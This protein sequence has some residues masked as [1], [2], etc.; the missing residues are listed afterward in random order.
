MYMPGRLRTASSPSRTVMFWASYEPLPFEPFFFAG[1]SAKSFL[2]PRKAPTPEPLS[3][4]SGRYIR[5][6]L[7]LAGYPPNRTTPE[8]TKRPQIA[9]KYVFS[10]TVRAR[11][12]NEPQLR[13]R[14]GS[15]SGL[16]AGEQVRPQ[17]LQFLRPDPRF[18]GHGD[19]AVTLR[20]G[21]RG[22]REPGARDLVPGR[23]DLG[24][25]GGRG[26]VGKG[27]LESVGE[28]PRSEASHR[29][30]SLAGV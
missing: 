14:S 11:I 23:L 5:P 7:I 9:T 24:E 2:P 4:G 10:A 30:E 25:E 3:A 29:A 12:R 28:E 18:T 27:A 8:A 21:C 15:E 1:C 20:N 22:G 13:H 6:L 19:H 16:E 17:E 26:D